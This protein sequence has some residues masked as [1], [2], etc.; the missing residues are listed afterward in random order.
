MRLE[1]GKKPGPY[2]VLAPLGAGGMGEVYRARDTRL[3]RDVAIKVLPAQSDTRLPGVSTTRP[4]CCANWRIAAVVASTSR[5]SH[6]WPSTWVRTSS[7]AIRRAL[8]KALAEA[9]PPLTL[10]VTGGQ[11]LETFRSD[12][13]IHRLLFDLYGW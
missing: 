12:P 13:E 7:P 5:R 11:F 3:D 2:E 9:T 4:A 10:R 8:S 6:R 1:I